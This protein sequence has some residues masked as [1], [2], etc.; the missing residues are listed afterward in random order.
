MARARVCLL[1]QIIGASEKLEQVGIG[2]GGAGARE[3][4]RVFFSS[5]APIF[6]SPPLSESRKQAKT[7]FNNSRDCS[8]TKII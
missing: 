5:I 1:S 6:R 2:D 7:T 8:F 4:E 3:R